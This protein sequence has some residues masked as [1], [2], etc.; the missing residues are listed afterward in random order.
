[1]QGDY[2]KAV[3]EAILGS[4]NALLE[5]P[6]GTGKTLC[7]L[8]AA[9]ASLRKLQEQDSNSRIQIIYCSRTFTQ[10]NQVMSE[11]RK[12][13]YAPKCV[14]LASK[15]KLCINENLTEKNEDGLVLSGSALRIGCKNLRDR[16]QCQFYCK[17]ES[18]KSKLHLFP[19]EALDIEELA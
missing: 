5:S 6:T 16:N 3:V 19:Q 1:M 18:N 7:L 9:L 15:D 10:L 12:T 17:K 13:A 4:K 14:T 8:T 11:L 2:I